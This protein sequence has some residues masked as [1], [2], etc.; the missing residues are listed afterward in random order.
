MIVNSLY[1][2]NMWKDFT[3]NYS[4]EAY[5]LRKDIDYFE[6]RG[7]LFYQHYLSNSKERKLVSNKYVEGVQFGRKQLSDY[8]RNMISKFQNTPYQT[9]QNPLDTHPVDFRVDWL[10]DYSIYSQGFLIKTDHT[11]W[12]INELKDF[13][14]LFDKI[15]SEAELA[16]IMQLIILNHNPYDK[17]KFRE[18]K[19]GYEVQV[20]PFFYPTSDGNVHYIPHETHIY[21]IRRD[22]KFSKKVVETSRTI[23]PEKPIHP[24]PAWAFGIGLPK[25]PKN[26]EEWIF[27]KKNFI[28]PMKEFYVF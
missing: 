15:D 16:F 1:A 23:L 27:E 13:F 12:I 5:S 6:L 18:V 19:D 21:T 4:K 11:I 20:K 28:T 24:D 10:L 17:M 25:K 22:G 9:N 3:H 26:I 7:Y 14:W 8:S 2:E